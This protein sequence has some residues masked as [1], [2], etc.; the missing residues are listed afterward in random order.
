M[1]PEGGVRT[2]RTPSLDPP[3]SYRVNV[4]NLQT[5]RNC[6]LIY[7]EIYFMLEIIDYQ[8]ENAK[9]ITKHLK[10]LLIFTLIVITHSRTVCSGF[11]FTI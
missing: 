6:W 4:N 11:T 10:Y 1:G 2:P 9:K 5:L 3:L 7:S 8:V